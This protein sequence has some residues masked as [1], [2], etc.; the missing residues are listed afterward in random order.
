MGKAER[1]ILKK[2]TGLDPDE[3]ERTFDVSSRELAA[4]HELL[5]FVV[6]VNWHFKLHEKATKAGEGPG[7]EM[8]VNGECTYLMVQYVVADRIGPTEVAIV[9]G[10]HGLR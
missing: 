6:P 10:K 4:A 2:A 1:F 5:Q 9:L 7:G 3:L 8:A